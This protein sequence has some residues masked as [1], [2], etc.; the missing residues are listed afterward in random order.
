MSQAQIVLSDS[1]QKAGHKTFEQS[2]GSF[3]LRYLSQANLLDIAEK[4]FYLT[5]LSLDE[6][7]RLCEAPLPALAK[8]VEIRRLT[9]ATST[10]LRLRA[11]LYFPIA[12]LLAEKGAESAIEAL[13]VKLGKVASDISSMQ[14]PIYL[15]VDNWHA[16]G[17]FGELKAL[18][19]QIIKKPAINIPLQILGPSTAE[20]KEV[21]RSL[22]NGSERDL[23]QLINSFKELRISGIE[24]GSD[25]EIHQ[26]SANQGLKLAFGQE[27]FGDKLSMHDFSVALLRVRDELSASKA[28]QC[29]FPTLTLD[30]D[31]YAG[32]SKEAVRL[33]KAIAIGYLSLSE[34]EFIRAPLTLFGPKLAELSASYGANDLGFA[35]IDSATSSEQG[36]FPYSKISAIFDKGEFLTTTFTF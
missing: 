15:V 3:S 14:G 13:T 33:L 26:L 27:I 32:V 35:A 24:G 30:S 31:G 11:V 7:I 17:K 5:P 22:K 36:V 29:W 34:V 9:I 23:S 12:T 16:Q 1:F 6:T 25:F 21:E 2:L 28:L 19:L 18:L 10:N 8:L 20:V 4:L